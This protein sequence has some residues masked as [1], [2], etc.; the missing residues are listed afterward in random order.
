MT[1]TLRNAAL[2]AAFILAGLALPLHAQQGSGP[3]RELDLRSIGPAVMGGRIHDVQ[4]LP[5]DPSTVY[6]AAA[7]G[8][9]WKSTNHGTT[10]TPVFDHEAT[11][12]FGVLA[13]APSDPQVLWAGTGEQNN[14]QSSSWGNGVYRSTDGG[15]TW[16][17]LGLDSTRAIGRI[18]VDPRDPNTAYVA[19]LGNLWKA[20]PERG[21]YK[22][23]DGGRTWTKSLFVDTL[24]GAVDLVMDPSDARTL[25]AAMYQRLRTPCC[26]NG[27]GAGSG[28]F[29][30]TDGGATWQRL[31]GGLPAGDVGR[32]GLAISRQNGKRVYAVVEAPA[33]GRAAG[34][35]RTDD[36]GD[37][38][39][40]VNALDPRPMYYSS[41]AVDP[42]N[43]ARVYMMARYFYRSDDAGATWRIMPTEPTYDVGLKGDYH[44]MWIDSGNPNHF[45]LAGDGGLYQSWDMGATYIRINNLPIGQFYGVG[46]DDETPFNIYGGMQDDHS[47][48]GP[49]ATRHYLGITDGDW[50]EIGFNDGVSGTVDRAGRHYVYS[51]AVDGDLTRVDATTGDR[52]DI[53]PV[54][55]AGKPPY[56]FE[57]ITPGLASRHLPG[58]YYYGGDRLFITHDRGRT[59]EPTKDLTRQVD[60]DTVR[61]MGVLDSQIQNSRNDGQ[62]A[63]SAI[64]AI[65]ESP[66][67][68]RV[69]WVGT[70][71]GNVQVSRDGGKTWTEVGHN[72]PGVP[73][74][75]YVSR[76]AATGDA[77][78]E[79]YVAFDNHRCGD[80]RPYAYHT[81]D[82]GATWTP[83]TAGLPGE[84]SVRTVGVYPGNGNVVFLGTEH[85]LYVSTD[86]G[87]HWGTLGS[88]LP[89]TLYM[90]VQ[91]QPSTKDVVVATHGRSLW[92]LDDGSALAEWSPK[93]AAEPAHLFDI[94]PATI[95]QYW[96]DYSYRGQNYWAGENPPDGA[97][98]DYSLARDAVEAQITVRNAKGVVV[99][100]LTGPG[101]AGAVHRVVWDL[102]YAPPPSMPD[103]NSYTR[104]ALPR[105]PRPTG[106]LGPFVS[107]GR[108]TVSLSANGV[109]VTRTVD[110]KPDPKM[111]LTQAQYREREAFL[112]ELLGVQTRAFEAAR[113]AQGR[114]RMAAM[115]LQRQAYALAAKFNGSGALS[116]TLYPP[117]PQQVAELKAIEAALN[118]GK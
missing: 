8:G 46:L 4:A 7:T 53:H 48:F 51:N 61:V 23:T 44:A 12:T 43:D 19:A 29:R 106:P 71:D 60:R 111:P 3:F 94:R 5:N 84:G 17:H 9:I 11:S 66:K 65:D 118:K 41:L 113:T 26:F 116:G 107:P 30:S 36:G 56:R 112:V 90:D 100:T 115:R 79:A 47:W 82:F 1:S 87:A 69:L 68:A 35:Y 24:T 63:F 6:I 81:T 99:R 15:A 54:A 75:S 77:P 104:E 108:Y 31:S 110:V 28:I 78:G 18:V 39:T 40:H 98:I 72:A 92:I 88:N 96:E 67:D 86:H 73:D 76:V 64:S 37:H 50:R 2:G 22:T 27:G 49:S 89:T 95:F 114:E 38:W 101:V 102:R 45:Y 59:W 13:I 52:A 62:T 105:P 85:A 32:I 109:T 33:A 83:I 70:D 10:W 16:T 58:V 20:S 117:T 74:G 21:V 25:Y 97:V 55:P 93:V 42:T 103:T 80:F 57:W 14:R 91:V 34:V